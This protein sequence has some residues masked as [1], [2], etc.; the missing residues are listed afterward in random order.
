M[1]SYA[2]N[3]EDVVLA[4][5]LPGDSGFYV[6]V[7]ASSPD[8]SS[9]TRHFYEQGW[10]GINIEP[11]DDAHELLEARRPR[12]IN[13]KV[14]VGSTDGVATFYRV[15]RDPDLSTTDEEDLA[16]L[17]ASGYE[18]EAESVEVR[19]LTSILD[20]HDVEHIDFLKIDAE[21]SEEAVLRGFDFVRWRPRVILIEAIR[22]WSRERADGRWR[23]L[24]ETQ[25]YVAALFDGINLFFGVEGDEAILGQLVPASPLDS[26]QPADVVAL[27][28]E[29]DFLRARLALA[30][31]ANDGSEPPEQLTPPR[32]ARLVVIGAPYSG[33]PMLRRGLAAA[34]GVVELV[35]EHPGDVDW[36]A[37]PSSF[38][39]ELC[40]AR[41]RRLK[42]TLQ[43]IGA[44]VIAPCPTP[45]RRPGCGRVRAGQPGGVRGRRLARDLFCRPADQLTTSGVCSR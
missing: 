18:Y 19:T 12:D 25:G 16:L 10:R 1:I 31:Q 30:E 9:V 37:L 21:G 38:V 28:E 23:N 2:E 39:M 32:L 24:L 44:I 41:T 36:Q 34:L 40:W 3:A 22:P 8:S 20:E 35:V 11:R 27:H 17:R 15:I 26:F 45:S 4:R 43:R 14:A 7:G 5:A 33:A 6:D 29:I 42:A 13:L